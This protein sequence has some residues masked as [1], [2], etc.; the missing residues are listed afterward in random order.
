[1]R[2]KSTKPS[3]SAD[4]LLQATGGFPPKSQRRIK[5]FSD[6]LLWKMI[7]FLCKTLIVRGLREQDRE[8]ESERTRKR[9]PDCISKWHH[10]RPAYSLEIMQFLREKF[11]LN[12]C[13]FRLWTDTTSY[14]SL[15]H[16]PH[17]YT[18]VHHLHW[19]QKAC[20]GVTAPR[21]QF[22]WATPGPRSLGVRRW[23]VSS[24]Q[25]IF[26]RFN[27]IRCFSWSDMVWL[28]TM[29]KIRNYLY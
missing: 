11:P 10:F 25:Q 18:T 16:K 7:R 9:L 19:L 24:F 15:S 1:M 17:S 2:E 3:R 8:W 26:P 5:V 27:F 22:C 29:I 4:R 6:N 21:A 28:K 14:I 23:F 20:S 13:F 12:L